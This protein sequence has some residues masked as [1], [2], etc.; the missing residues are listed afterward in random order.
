M[1][2]LFVFDA[3]VIYFFYLTKKMH[4]FLIKMFIFLKNYAFCNNIPFK[5]AEEAS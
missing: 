5:V 2:I 4:V 3:K 1:K